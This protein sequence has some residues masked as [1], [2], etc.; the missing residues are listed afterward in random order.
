[1]GLRENH[2]DIGSTGSGP[3]VGGR[4]RNITRQQER[5]NRIDVMESQNSFSRDENEDLNQNDDDRAYFEG[6]DSDKGKSN[7]NSRN[8][9]T[10][11][12][13]PPLR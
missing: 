8:N 9:T 6:G 11:Q 5:K 7:N 1:M 3:E 12:R 2:A 4:Y 10:K 13:P